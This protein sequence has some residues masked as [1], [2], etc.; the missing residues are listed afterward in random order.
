LKS[1]LISSLTFRFSGAELD[2]FK[3][4]HPHDWL[5]WEPGS[6]KPPGSTTLVGPGLTTT[7]T[8]GRPTGEAL[9]LALEPKKDGSQLTLGRGGECDA[10]INDGTLS[11]L[12]LVFMQSAGGVWTVRDAG[13]RNGSSI[14]G[15]KLQPG[16]PMPLKTGCKLT[17]AGVAFTFY[18]PAGMLQRLKAA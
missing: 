14:D 3:K 10:V 8:P 6:W 2:S 15:I 13:S 12:H 18:G 17:A 4:A 16:T 11:T 7:P 9:A 5:L 1:Y